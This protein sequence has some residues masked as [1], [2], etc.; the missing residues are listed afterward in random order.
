[1]GRKH[2]WFWEAYPPSNGRRTGPIEDALDELLAP[3]MVTVEHIH[4]GALAYAEQLFGRP[5]QD[6]KYTRH[7][8]NWLKERGWLDDYPKAQVIARNSKTVDRDVEQKFI[9]YPPRKNY[10]SRRAEER[11]KERVADANLTLQDANFGN[12]EAQ[13]MVADMLIH[14]KFRL[15]PCKDHASEAQK[16]LHKSIE[17]GN[18]RAKI[19][20]GDN[21]M[22]GRG[23]QINFIEGFKWYKEAG[24]AG[25]SRAFS[26]VG[27]CY[28]E[29]KGIEQN[30]GEAVAWLARA[31]ECEGKYSSSNEF[32][33][34]AKTAL[35]YAETME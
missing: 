17:G 35:L 2:E 3:G 8:L 28:L 27:K 4:S 9:R 7:P 1:L 6:V 23:A 21:Y 12:H 15:V 25:E 13:R 24:E 18:T 31:V 11:D 20:L 5:R 22:N 33:E 30:L 10:P 16:W 34:K 14:G 19:N 29:G 26:R 32:L